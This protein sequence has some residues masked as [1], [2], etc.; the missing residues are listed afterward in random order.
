MKHAAAALALGLVALAPAA[1]EAGSSAWEQAQ[2]GGVR[3]VAASQA[4]PDGTLRAAL[5]IDL[6]P[7]WKTY[8]LDPGSSGVPPTI[9]LTVDGQPV[10]VAVDLP[11]PQRFDDGY[12]SFAGYA[13][14]VSLALTFRPPVEPKSSVVDFSVFVGICETICIPVQATL[15]VDLA[16]GTP[17]DEAA[18]DAA[19]AALPGPAR[20][21]FGIASAWVEGDELIVTTAAPDGAA[22]VELFVAST[23]SFVFGE[24]KAS[25][26]GRSFRVP[27]LDR[28]S[29]PVVATEAARYTLIAD[30]E[31][32]AGTVAI[33]G[34][35]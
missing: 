12:S 35:P 4:Q 3:I 22:N 34:H 15:A 1:A 30:G 13:A 16:T 25:A 11:A 27:L 5:E 18:V 20:P 24:P 7:G 2:G 8:W 31:A 14:P 17:E 33:S 29:E 32:V 6:K 10:A 26:D 19:F 23:P 21:D 28:P 9:E